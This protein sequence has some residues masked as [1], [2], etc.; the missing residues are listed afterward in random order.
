MRNK[1][2]VPRI[3]PGVVGKLAVEAGGDAELE[4]STD[5]ERG[6]V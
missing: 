5:S 4:R 3:E 1:G 2:V 6:G